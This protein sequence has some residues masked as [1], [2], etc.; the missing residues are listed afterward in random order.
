GPIVEYV[1]LGFGP[2]GFVVLTEQLPDPPFQFVAPAEG[3]PLADGA[4]GTRQVCERYVGTSRLP[5]GLG[6]RIGS[7]RGTAAQQRV[8]ARRWCRCRC[9]GRGSAGPH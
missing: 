4:K 5:G 2:G 7:C 1:L 9:W 3:H 8:P 6:R